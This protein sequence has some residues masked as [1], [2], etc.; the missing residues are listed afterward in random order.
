MTTLSSWFQLNNIPSNAINGQYDLFLVG[1]SCVVTV[2]AFYVVLNIISHIRAEKNQYIEMCWMLGGAF[3]MGAGIWSMHFIGMLAF[4]MPVPM[5][6]DLVWTGASLLV[7]ILVSG[8]ILFM[9][10]KKKYSFAQLALSGF[11]I[12]LAI[13]TMHYMGMEGMKFFIN[14]HYLPGLFFL[15]F[16]ISI[17]ASQ[18]ALYLALQSHHGSNQRQFYFKIM[19]ALVMGVAVCGTHYTGMAAAVFTPNPSHLSHLSNQEIQS[20]YLAL[21]I[22]GITSLIIIVAFSASSSYKKIITAVGNKRDFLN[23]MLDNL[24]DGIIACDSQG[25]ITVFNRALQKNVN[26]PADRMNINDLQNYFTLSTMDNTLLQKEERPLSRVL[27]GESIHGIELKMNFKNNIVRDVVIDA[28]NIVNSDGKNLGAVA[29]IHDVT[30]LKKTEKLKNEFVSIVSHELRTP[31]TSIRGA[32]GLLESGIMGEFSEKAK[33][34]L[35]I[36]N[37]NCE[38]LLLLINDILDIEKIEAG[39]MEF[40]LKIQNLYQIV[41]EA[42]ASNKMYAD[43]YGVSIEFTQP[44]SSYLVNVDSHRLTQVLANLISNACK[45]SP[46]GGKII[47]AIEQINE[48]VRVS[49]ADKGPGIPEEFQ[50]RIFQKF[51]QA[52]SSDTRR[53]DGT[54]LGLNISKTIIEKLGG[55]LGFSSQPNIKTTFYFDLPIATQQSNTKNLAEADEIK[56]NAIKRRLLICED[57][58]DQSEYLKLLLESSG[59]IID[60]ATTVAQAKKLLAEHDYH[61]LLL[62]L[63]LPDQD[64]IAF[65]RELRAAEK[66]K[67]LNIIVVSV[68]AQTG[69]SLLN[70]DAV[71][72]VDWFDKPIDFTKL[73]TA[74]NRIKK[75]SNSALPQILHIED[76]IDTQH[77]VGVLLERYAFVSTA[78][79]LQQ[80]KEMLENNDYDLI[81][82]DLVLPDGN[83]V[84]ILPLLA[85]HRSPVVVFSDTQ[86]NDDYAKFVNQALIKS[87]SSSETFVNT[88]MHL[89]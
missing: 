63:I 32:L 55:T 31:I 68:I 39:K 61:A 44:E 18:I 6:Y 34:L 85:Q 62:D 14:I 59:F 3:T 87:N 74:I 48:S 70:G 60:I 72:V 67:N 19:S 81:I 27:K 58:Q 88:I 11:I 23:A 42:I 64:G 9:L 52:D 22:A 1:L 37:S 13:A 69:H 36:A 8:L 47:L 84:E 76:D 35:D 28:Q 26:C 43:K 45:F 10:Q 86:L 38:R 12:G 54:G 51:S 17:V 73:L 41:T 7:A 29:V 79:N 56:I 24:E 16:V 25:Q 77:I 50:S 82:L 30:E 75:K 83:G 89:L 5:K 15:S 2:F 33:K 78:N 20:N 53:K 49:V 4:M 40:C 65:I 57:D 80:A 71:S 66:T 21:F 46:K